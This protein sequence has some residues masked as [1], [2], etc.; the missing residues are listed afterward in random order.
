[1]VNHV[2]HLQL[3]VVG[4]GNYSLDTGTIIGWSDSKDHKVVFDGVVLTCHDSG[5]IT[6]RVLDGHLVIHHYASAD[7]GVD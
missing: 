6:N 2:T 1:M 4:S 7:G 3:G 5:S